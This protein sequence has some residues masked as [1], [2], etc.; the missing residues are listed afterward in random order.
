MRQIMLET[1]QAQWVREAEGEVEVVDLE[2]HRLGTVLEPE[3]EE[4]NPI[5]DVIF[6]CFFICLL[7]L[8]VAHLAGSANEIP[9]T[10]LDLSS[11]RSLPRSASGQ[12]TRIVLSVKQ[13]EQDAVQLW[14]DQEPVSLGQLESKLKALGGLAEVALRREKPV[15]VEIEDQ[16][17]AACQRAG[18]RRITFLVQ[19]EKGAER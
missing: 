6:V 15:T 13:D 4:H 11:F 7:R 5:I 12:D 19:S 9:L 14:I 16:I 10:D 2:G 8:V 1:E 17:I 3:E 18:I